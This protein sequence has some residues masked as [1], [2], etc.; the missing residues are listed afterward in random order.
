MD[1]LNIDLDS[2]C[3]ILDILGCA[4]DP[5][6]IEDLC[7]YCENKG[8]LTIEPACLS[9]H[10]SGHIEAEDIEISFWSGT[11]LIKGTLLDMIVDRLGYDLIKQ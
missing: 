2:A 3:E 1:N 9:Q 4:E 7:L 11:K 5:I 6:Q 8:T 10:R